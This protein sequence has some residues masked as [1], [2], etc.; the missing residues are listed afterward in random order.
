MSFLPAN[1][2]VCINISKYILTP[3]QLPKDYLKTQFTV[4]L[5]PHLLKWI[6]YIHELLNFQK[7]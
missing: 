5:F 4:T 2:S 7:K 3:S 1:T 6:V